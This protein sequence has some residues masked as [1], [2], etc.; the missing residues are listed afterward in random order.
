MISEY[1]KF[2]DAFM[3][4]LCAATGI[5]KEHLEDVFVSNHAAWFQRHYT[6]AG[7]W[8]DMIMEG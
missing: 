3:K 6:Q 2:L 1:D 5:P 4:H 7:P 8:A